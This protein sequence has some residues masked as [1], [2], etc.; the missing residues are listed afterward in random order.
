LIVLSP[1]SVLAYCV[2]ASFRALII[3]IDSVVKTGLLSEE[4]HAIVVLSGTVIHAELVFGSAIRITAC[5][6]LISHIK[7]AVLAEDWTAII[8]LVSALILAEFI[9]A[10]PT[11][12]LACKSV[13]HAFGLA[14]DRHTVI[15][16]ID[17]IVDAQ[18]IFSLA[19]TIAFSGAGISF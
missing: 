7:T 15:V 5:C 16:L 10:V 9:I 17:A 13:L 8:V 14:E 6:T 4:W 2:I 11:L 12:T 19:L 1:A 18:L 3:A